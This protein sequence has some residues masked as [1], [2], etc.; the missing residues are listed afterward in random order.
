MF[1]VSAE[2][3]PEAKSGSPLVEGVS[4]EKEEGGRDEGE[5]EVAGELSL[6]L[7]EILKTCDQIQQRAG[8][9]GDQGGGGGV[10]E[11]RAEPGL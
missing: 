8:A 2:D 1:P 9:T 10:Q 5:E 4:L 11:E 7:E 3:L 6:E